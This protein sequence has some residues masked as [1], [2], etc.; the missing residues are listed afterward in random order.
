MKLWLHMAAVSAC[1]AAVPNVH[2]QSYPSKPITIIVPASPGGVTD[3]LARIL[4]Q[5]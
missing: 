1:L 5:H 4:A 3:M 2:A